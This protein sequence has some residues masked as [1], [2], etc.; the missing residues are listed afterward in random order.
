MLLDSKQFPVE[1]S[2]QGL[3][4]SFASWEHVVKTKTSWQFVT[5]D[6]LIFPQFGLQILSKTGLQVKTTI[7][8]EL[9]SDLL[10]F[11]V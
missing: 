7:I 3:K 6:V 10:A 5:Q 9:F 11:V 2:T 1:E 8:A 4:S